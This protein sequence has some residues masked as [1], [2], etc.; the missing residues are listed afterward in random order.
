LLG[1][2]RRVADRALA[3]IDDDL[4]RLASSSCL[5]V[6]WRNLNPRPSLQE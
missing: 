6:L 4:L 5:I 2:P 3:M 1:S